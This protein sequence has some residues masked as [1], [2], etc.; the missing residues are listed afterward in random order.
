MIMKKQ[1]LKKEITI[2]NLNTKLENAGFQKDKT[3]YHILEDYY[4]A[5]KQ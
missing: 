2:Q 1:I 3:G 4:N 5:L